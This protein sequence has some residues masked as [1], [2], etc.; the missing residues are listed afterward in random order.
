MS[1]IVLKISGE[2]LKGDTQNVSNDKLDIVLKTVQ[3]LRKNNHCVGIVVGGGNFFRG[4]ENPTMNKVTA[5]TIGML[6]T[7]MNALY[8][9]DYFSKNAIDCVVSTPF[10]FTGLLDNLSDEEL[11]DRYE[12]GQVVI[13]GGGVGMSGYSTDSGTILASEKLDSDLIIKMTNVDGVYSSDP[14]LDKDAIK[15]D[16][17]TYKDVID[18]KLQVMDE[19][20][21]KKCMENKIKIL[22]INFNDYQ[23]LDKFF[24]N[25]V[26][27]TVIGE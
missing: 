10:V 7:V 22:V 4:R 12:D 1:R 15:Y 23:N 2:A 20:A 19:Y 3:Y 9:K 24:N 8:L 11:K 27:G 26:F 14:R 6:G 18:N 25:E 21:I 17:L 13:F 16:R 5:D